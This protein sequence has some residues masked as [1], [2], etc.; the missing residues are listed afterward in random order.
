MKNRPPKDQKAKSKPFPV[1][2]SDNSRKFK[3]DKRKPDKPEDSTPKVNFVLHPNKMRHQMK[4][5]ENQNRQKEVQQRKEEKAKAFQQFKAKKTERNK[6]ITH[7]TKRGQP[8]MKGRMEMMLSKI[9]AQ[10]ANDFSRS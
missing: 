1:N 2:K 4:V 3:K 7:K 8:V 10:V 5:V 6:V 9:Q